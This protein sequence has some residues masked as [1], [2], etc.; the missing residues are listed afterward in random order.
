MLSAFLVSLTSSGG[1][2]AAHDATTGVLDAR[3]QGAKVEED[4]L[5]QSNTVIITTISPHPC[6]RSRRRSWLQPEWWRQPQ[7]AQWSG[8]GWTCTS[9][10]SRLNPCVV[11]L[12][13]CRWTVL[14]GL[15]CQGLAPTW[16]SSGQVQRW[17]PAVSRP[18][19][20]QHLT[21]QAPHG[22][23]TYF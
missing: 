9:L 23:G 5:K 4:V 2:N 22:T 21:E 8:T 11:R 10:S 7:S 13:S 19:H 3:G 18:R 16:G 17:R 15:Y 6:C 14:Q 12:T 1:D 20:I